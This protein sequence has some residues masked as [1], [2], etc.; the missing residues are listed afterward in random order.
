MRVCV[1]WHHNKQINLVCQTQIISGADRLDPTDHKYLKVKRVKF[2]EKNTDPET[3]KPQPRLMCY[4]YHN[5]FF[6]L[7]ILLSQSKQSK[8]ISSF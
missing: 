2:N 5:F 4:F 1:L 3:M 8:W 7:S 6:S